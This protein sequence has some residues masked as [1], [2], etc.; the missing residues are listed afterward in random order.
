MFQKNDKSFSKLWDKLFW[1]NLVEV[2][3]YPIGGRYRME[4]K[5][6]MKTYSVTTFNASSILG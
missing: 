6:I 4:F 1:T 3:V 5:L 2:T